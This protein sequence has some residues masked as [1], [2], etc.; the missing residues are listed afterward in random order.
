MNP[1]AL[2]HFDHMPQALSDAQL[3]VDRAKRLGYTVPP[4]LDVL[5]GYHGRMCILLHM[6]D[7]TE[8]TGI[9]ILQYIGHVFKYVYICTNESHNIYIYI[10]VCYHFVILHFVSQNIVCC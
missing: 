6:F 1:S 4:W 2:D 8:H 5:L 7:Y 9:I 3:A 10:C